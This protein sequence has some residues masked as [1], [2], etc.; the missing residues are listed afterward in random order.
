MFS[1]LL[2]S[3][4]HTGRRSAICCRVTLLMLPR[5][6]RS[7]TMF[8]RTD[9]PLR[10]SPMSRM[11]F[12]ADQPG[13]SAVARWFSREC[14]SSSELS[15]SRITSK[16]C[17]LSSSS[18]L[19]IGSSTFGRNRPSG[20][21]RTPSSSRTRRPTLVRISRLSTGSVFSVANWR[22]MMSKLVISESLAN[23][24]FEIR[25]PRCC[26]SSRLSGSQMHSSAGC[27]P[28]SSV[29]QCAGM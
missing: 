16:T 14:A 15:Q 21:D 10:P 25:L 23:R 8:S 17:C 4:E 9:L 27:G 24:M 28:G 22:S 13:L 26:L 20:L 5:P 3:S 7:E 18:S 19:S 2:F 11:Y 6:N 1:S 29:I 12:T